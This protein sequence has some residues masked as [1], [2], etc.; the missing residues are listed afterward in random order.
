MWFLSIADTS[1][2]TRATPITSI[3]STAQT[4]V[5][6]SITIQRPAQITLAT[7]GPVVAQNVPS[8][9]TYHVPRGPAVVANLAA[10]R[11]NVASAIRAP[12][13]VTAQTSGQV[14]EKIYFS[15]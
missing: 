14:F 12:M 15:L 9:A 1:G 6:G 10:P 7:T 8:G 5:S 4:Q 3:I 11:S 13:V 2:S